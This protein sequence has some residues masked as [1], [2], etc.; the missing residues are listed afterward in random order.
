MLKRCEKG[1]GS[2]PRWAGQ[3]LKFL[4][5]A[6]HPSISCHLSNEDFE[7]SIRIALRPAAVFGWE[8]ACAC[9]GMR[10]Y[11]AS[12]QLAGIEC[13]LGELQVS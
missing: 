5:E 9:L 11:L 8:F 2:R 12:Q 7:A 13:C 10:C 4:I 1:K 6:C 3:G